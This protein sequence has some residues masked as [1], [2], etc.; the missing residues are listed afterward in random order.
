MRV[1]ELFA[2]VGG[3]RLGLEPSGWEIVWSNQ[4]EPSTRVQHASECY[5]RHFGKESHVCE[6]IKK[7]LDD[8]E[9]GKRSIP[10]HELL[11][12][13]FPCQ[14]YSVARALSQAV[15]IQGK[16]GVLWWEIHRLLRIKRPPFLFL[17]NVDRLLSSP[18]NQR[19]RDFAIMLACLSD[20]GYLVEWRVINAA[21]YGFPQKRRRVL[22][23]GQLKDAEHSIEEPLSLVLRDG[24][25]AKALPLKIDVKQPYLSVDDTTL[26]D[27]RI[28]GDIP[29]VSA[30][31]GKKATKTPFQ[32]AGLVYKRNVWTRK[33]APDYNGR[34]VSLKDILQ[35]ES[36]VDK[37]LFIPESQLEKWKYLKGAKDEERVHKPS[38][39]RYHYKEGSI[40]FPDDIDGPSRTV[41]TGEGG[42]TPSRFKHIIPAG[43][44]GYRRLSPIELERLN[45]FPDGWT[46]GIGDGKRAFLMGNALVVGLV[47]CV[48]IVLADVLRQK[49]PN[50]S[51]ISPAIIRR[52]KDYSASYPIGL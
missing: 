15:G 18:A 3:F 4:W 43:R 51:I 11:V 46:A 26:P 2:G 10:D 50:Q 52:T 38:G 16:K 22:I 21:D 36:D 49:E 37:S 19:G 27:F 48:G 31:F 42:S 14:D 5:V 35:D 7:V 29:S 39:Y 13:G 17:E 23:V 32:N 47:E 25:L 30:N 12:G 24:I 34:R 40:P 20:L 1:V 9:A 28:E 8:V 33:V 6:D 45:G 41:L 44:G